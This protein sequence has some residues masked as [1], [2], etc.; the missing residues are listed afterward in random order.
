MDIFLK[1]I[2]WSRQKPYKRATDAEPLWTKPC[3][4]RCAATDGSQ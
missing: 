2:F 4:Q 1:A 3:A